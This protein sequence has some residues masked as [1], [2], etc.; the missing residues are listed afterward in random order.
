MNEAAAA[1]VVLLRAYESTG[2]APWSDADRAWAGRAALQAVGAQATADDFLATRARLGLQRLASQDPRLVRWQALRPWRAEALLAVVVL[3]LLFGFLV[4]RIGS[5]QR[6]NLLAPP[7]W[8]VIVWN[9]AV[10]V[11]LLGQSALGVAGPGAL[12][13][14]LAAALRRWR[15]RGLSRGDGAAAAVWKAFA[16]D[17]ATLSLPLGGARIALAL[18]LGAAAMA[19]GLIVGMYL[20][21]LVLDYRAGWESTFLDAGTV[22]AVLSA[23]LAPASVVSGIAVPDAAAMQALRVAPG[24]AGEASAAPW[25][26]LYA[27]QLLLLVVLPRLLLA[28]RAGLRARRLAHDFALPLHEPYFQRLSTLQSGE[29]RLVQLWPH[30][31]AP[32]AA[33]QAALGRLFARVLGDGVVLR[34]APPVAYGDEDEVAPRAADGTV[35]VALFDLAA[36]PEPDSQGR[37]LQALAAGGVPWVLVDEGAFVARFGANATRLPARREAWSALAASVGAEAVFV[38]LREA[39]LSAAEAALQAASASPSSAS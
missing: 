34:F 26:H 16:A 24:A 30:A 2:F 27:W 23:L 37:L 1:Q 4:D 21:G 36:T 6:I 19:L 31:Q 13:L 32:D 15:T 8:A 25:I 18:H 39:D 5:T 12:R 28:L 7:V 38:N 29:Q 10:F 20:R 3:G 33:A 9:L 22:S 17:W 14:G 11:W 35:Q